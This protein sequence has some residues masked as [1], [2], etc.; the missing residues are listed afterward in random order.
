MEFPLWYSKQWQ[1][2]FY[3]INS[4]VFPD[5]VPNTPTYS[6][7][8]S[9]SSENCS[10]PGLWSWLT[11]MLLRFNLI[12]FFLC[13]FV[14]TTNKIPLTFSLLR[15]QVNPRDWYLKTWANKAQ[16]SAWP[17]N[18]KSKQENM[19]HHGGYM[20]D[21]NISIR[22]GVVIRQTGITCINCVIH[23]NQQKM[24]MKWRKN[25]HWKIWG[26]R[27]RSR[28]ERKDRGIQRWFSFGLPSSPCWLG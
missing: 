24:K 8:E 20:V 15:W 7:V 6:S 23:N 28:F 19:Y 1:I 14:S 12:T 17:D 22:Y 2:R 5:I 27:W 3:K 26:K 4:H 10:Q 21:N 13:N 18:T 9:G 11:R 16:P 25:K